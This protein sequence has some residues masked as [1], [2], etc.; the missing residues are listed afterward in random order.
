MTGITQSNEQNKAVSNTLNPFFIIQPPPIPIVF[1]R[2]YMGSKR[3]T[4]TQHPNYENSISSR[5]RIYA[6]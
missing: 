1:S 2:Q 5:R 3:G 4:N 6:K